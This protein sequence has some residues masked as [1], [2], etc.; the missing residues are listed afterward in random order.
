QAATQRRP[1]AS[2]AV[3][4]PWTERRRGKL[5]LSRGILFMFLLASQLG[6]VPRN[7]FAVAEG[8][9]TRGQ[10][11]HQSQRGRAESVWAMLAEAAKHPPCSSPPCVEGNRIHEEWMDIGEEMSRVDG[12][13]VVRRPELIDAGS[14]PTPLLSP[15]NTLDYVKTLQSYF[16]I[17]RDSLFSSMMVETQEGLEELPIL[18]R[19]LDAVEEGDD[20]AAKYLSASYSTG[21]VEEKL[22][23]DGYES[24]SAV[25][26][27]ADV[28]INRDG[29]FWNDKVFVAPNSCLSTE[30]ASLTNTRHRPDT[31]SF[32]KV[33]VLAQEYGQAYYHLLVE[34]LS[35]ITVV[36]DLL[37]E[38]PDIKIH[39]DLA[40]VPP[41]TVC[42]KPNAAMVNLLRHHL[43]QFN[44]EDFPR[45]HGLYPHTGG[46]PPV[47]P[48]PVIVLV[49]RVKKRGL[50]N[51]AEVREA[52][53]QNFPDFDVVEFDGIQHIRAQLGMFAKASMIVGP[54]G[55]GLSNMVVSPLHTM[56][57]EI[58]PID[59]PTCYVNLAI[60]LQHIYARHTGSDRGD[61]PCDSWYE[62]NVDEVVSLAR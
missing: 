52:L 38:N 61:D 1:L 56:I 3:A 35:R 39:A 60:K 23:S 12:A 59:C 47:P 40:I 31:E 20:S 8:Q 16:P 30:K 44:L 14:S 53:A 34:N 55:A 9:D 17:F 37:M 58:G 42:G 27:M 33:V 32:E 36:K 57:L 28:F 51:N 13:A 43:L 6:H 2:S 10:M 50:Q 48:R 22:A 26:S 21:P 19:F 25:A 18:Q 46:V 45:V 7:G 29:Y 49:V 5:D 54:H 11:S 15:V 62:P 24:V 41:S 4:A